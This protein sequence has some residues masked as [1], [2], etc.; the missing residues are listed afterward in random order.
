[1][2]NNT[3]VIVRSLRNMKSIS[4]ALV[5]DICVACRK[6]SAMVIVIVAAMGIAG[7]FGPSNWTTGV[8][9]G[10]WC[11]MSSFE[12]RGMVVSW[13]SG[14]SGHCH[15]LASVAMQWQ[16]RRLFWEL[17]V[18]NHDLHKPTLS[19]ISHSCWLSIGFGRLDICRPFQTSSYEQ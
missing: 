18:N 9:H 17:S 8:T 16:F 1:M 15:C 3:A 11:F 14:W 6:S 7:V 4:R 13:L 10:I 2:I 5:R 19:D 12:I